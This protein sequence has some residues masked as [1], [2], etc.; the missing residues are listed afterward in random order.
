MADGT[1]STSGAQLAVTTTAR[2]TVKTLADIGFN[3]TTAAR[4]FSAS[5]RVDAETQP[6]R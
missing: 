5:T 6:N 4:G 2:E 1:P 3:L